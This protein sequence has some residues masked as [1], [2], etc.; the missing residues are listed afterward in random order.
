[1]IRKNETAF[2]ASLDPKG[3]LSSI[4]TVKLAHSEPIANFSPP[5]AVL[6]QAK[7]ATWQYN[8]VIS[9]KYYAPHF[10][11]FNC[12]NSTLNSVLCYSTTLLIYS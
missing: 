10:F 7:S 1:M 5:K 8:K 9:W 2:R 4:V 3:T 6:K 12:C 11:V